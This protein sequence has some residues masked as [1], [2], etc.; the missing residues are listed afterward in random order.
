M[1]DQPIPGASRPPMPEAP[2]QPTEAQITEAEGMHAIQA[3]ANI[4]AS[5]TS[6]KTRAYATSVLQ[7]IFP[8]CQVCSE[9]KESLVRHRRPLCQKV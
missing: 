5:S 7:Q 4:E 1:N 3:L 9:K 8:A 6:S 2:P